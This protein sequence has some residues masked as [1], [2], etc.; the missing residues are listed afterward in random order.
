MLGSALMHFGMHV[1]IF[2][3]GFLALANAISAFIILPET[4]KN[5]KTDKRLEWHPFSPVIK[6]FKHK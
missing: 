1:P 6:A 3:T 4:N 5:K 2:F